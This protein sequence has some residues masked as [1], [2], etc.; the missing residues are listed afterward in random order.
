MILRQLTASPQSFLYATPLQESKKQV[1][2]IPRQ[3]AV[4]A[5]NASDAEFAVATISAYG[6]EVAKH[7]S[8]SALA[9]EIRRAANGHPVYTPDIAILAGEAAQASESPLDKLTDLVPVLVTTSA[10][11]TDGAVQLMRQGVKDVVL[12]P[13]SR[14]ELW[15]RISQTLESSDAEAACKAK[16]MEMASRFSKLTQAELDVVDALLD[17]LANKQI[18]ERLSIG[19]RTVELRRSKIMRKMQARS[20]AELVKFIC[21]AGKLTPGLVK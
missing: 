2:Y 17:G 18:A 19:L 7:Q 9:D 13:C 4:I 15:A 8:A 5:A 16:A 6:F 14:E 11:T 1:N 21:I 20:V 12:L 3:A 10:T